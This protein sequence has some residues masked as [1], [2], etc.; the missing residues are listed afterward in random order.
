MKRYPLQNAR[1]YIV[2]AFTRLN[3]VRGLDLALLNIEYADLMGW[4]FIKVHMLDKI[5]RHGFEVMLNELIFTKE[6]A[7]TNL[8]AEAKILGKALPEDERIILRIAYTIWK[9]WKESKNDE[10]D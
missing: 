10:V 2:K 7:M 8:D 3:K 6:D 1:K 4:D 5:L 9:D